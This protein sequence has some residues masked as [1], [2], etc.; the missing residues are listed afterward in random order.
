MIRNNVF[1]DHE[2]DHFALEGPGV[3]IATSQDGLGGEVVDNEFVSNDY[4]VEIAEPQSILGTNIS[5]R[6]NEFESND[7]G[8]AVYAEADEMSLFNNSFESHASEAVAY[9]ID[10]PQHYLNAT[11]NWWGHNT[12][13][14]GDVVDP[15]SGVVADGQGDNVSADVIFDPWLGAAELEISGFADQLPEADG[16]QDFGTVA[17]D[18]EETAAI[19]TEN[20]EVTLEVSNDSTAFTS[21][22][23]DELL[24]AET[25]ADRELVN[26]TDTFSF[27]VGELSVGVG[28]AVRV[29]ADAD[30]ADERT[31]VH[32]VRGDPV[33]TIEIEESIDAEQ[34]E[35]DVAY[36][37]EN[38]EEGIGIIV[39][40]NATGESVEEPIWDPGAVGNGSI[41][42][43]VTE[44]G[45]I[46]DGDKI[47]AEIESMNEPGE[48]LDTDSVV[49]GER[50]VSDYANEDGIVDTPGLL[51][52]IADWRDGTS[53]T[54][55]LVSVIDAWRSED[56]VD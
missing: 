40:N 17:V 19:E 20:L 47:T 30:N 50:S 55:L 51:D 5:V 21:H 1:T 53:D 28:Y 23:G 22:G 3:R 45:G 49:V 7:Y 36:S 33:G 9:N 2:R 18:V 6:E 14:G 41:R 37:S 10:D 52:A 32:Q 34:T 43:Q 25:I 31:R 12:G 39:E 11:H 54:D 42:V 35:I 24:Y 15:V 29:I 8:V 16:E 27:E 4:G 44:L 38:S 13:P 46:E 26:E 48:A 56:P